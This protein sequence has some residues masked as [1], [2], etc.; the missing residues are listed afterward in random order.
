MSAPVDQSA[1]STSLLEEGEVC[2]SSSTSPRV[3]KVSSAG[4]SKGFWEVFIRSC[5]PADKDDTDQCVAV[6]S[7]VGT[8]G[9]MGLVMAAH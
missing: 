2:W 3:L 6:V 9:D 5:V 8:A 7:V 4:L 1:A